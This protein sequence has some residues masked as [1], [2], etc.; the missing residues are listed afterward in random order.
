MLIWFKS[1]VSRKHNKSSETKSLIDIS[2]NSKKILVHHKEVKPSLK[3]NFVFFSNWKI[4]SN[5]WIQHQLLEKSM[6]TH[7]DNN[8]NWWKV[9]K[10]GDSC[11]FVLDTNEIFDIFEHLKT[12]AQC[13]VFFVFVSSRKI[14]SYKCDI[15][16]WMLLIPC[17]IV[18]LNKDF[19]FDCRLCCRIWYT[20]RYKL[21]LVPLYVFFIVSVQNV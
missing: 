21:I 13:C 8:K 18:A 6:L 4:W 15:L 17:N 9:Y 7:M 2:P 11:Y 1:K 5:V 3:W 12:W 14:L 20:C 19:H 10:N 16:C